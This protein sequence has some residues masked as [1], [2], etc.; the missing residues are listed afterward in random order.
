MAFSTRAASQLTDGATHPANNSARF[1][2]QPRRRNLLNGG[3]SCRIPPRPTS[4]IRSHHVIP[5]LNLFKRSREL[6][7]VR[8][9]QSIWST[10]DSSHFERGR[11]FFFFF[12][13]NKN[14]LEWVLCPWRWGEWESGACSQAAS[15]ASG[16][17]R[18]ALS[19]AD[20]VPN[21]SHRAAVASSRFAVPRSSRCYYDHQNYW[22]PQQLSSSRDARFMES[23]LCILELVPCCLSPLRS[24]PPRL[25]IAATDRAGHQAQD[26]QSAAPSYTRVWTRT[27]VLPK[28][29]LPPSKIL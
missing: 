22:F 21:A 3:A 14:L 23:S 10:F 9:S 16:V 19:H 28:L 18:P 24:S 2:Q 12:N 1:G 29:Y 27:V 5:S 8:I 15:L 4:T 13:K 26:T 25:F 17:C 20:P 11:D 7:P 6:I